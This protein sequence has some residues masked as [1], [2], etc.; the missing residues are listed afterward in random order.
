MTSQAIY[1]A[2]IDGGG[3]GCRMRIRD[4][5]NYVLSEATGGPAN[6][7]QDATTALLNIRGLIQDASAKAGVDPLQ[8]HVGLGLAGLVTSV[9]PATLTAEKLGVARAIADV[10]AYT[11]CLGAFGGGDGGIVIAGTGSIGFGVSNG[12]R[13]VVGGWG[14]LLGD[15]GSGAWLGLEAV[16]HTAMV[17]DGFAPET[18]LS[19]RVKALAGNT[20]FDVSTWSARAT[21]KDYGGLAPDVFELAAKSEAAS[22][23]I[24]LEGAKAITMLV[25]S[26]HGKGIPEV[27]LLGGLAGL[28][29]RYLK[30]EIARELVLPI[31]DAL[32][33]AIW[34]ARH[35]ER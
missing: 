35:H 31:A 3:T 19:R 30:D 12:Q 29:P 23:A 17:F 34:M 1:F 6:F 20:M 32:E 33:G 5:D 15:R 4:S 9:D 7:Y 26:L 10:D 13:H 21:P 11:A 25:Q 18:D 22:L 28:Y 24:V 16:R 2:G 14:M 8:L 27:S